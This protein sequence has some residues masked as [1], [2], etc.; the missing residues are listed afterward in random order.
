MWALAPNKS[1]SGNSTLAFL[2]STCLPLSGHFTVLPCGRMCF[3]EHSTS[4]FICVCSGPID[5]R[6]MDKCLLSVT[7]T[8]VCRHT[9]TH[10]HLS[11]CAS[12]VFV[13]L[14]EIVYEKCQHCRQGM[15]SGKKNL[16]NLEVLNSLNSQNKSVLDV[17]LHQA[18]RLLYVSDLKHV[19]D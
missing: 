7:Q 4:D 10:L 15:R 16:R 2:N 14:A 5:D 11:Y 9:H 6:L 1:E 17:I 12:G 13:G 3:W 19:Q 8:H 18:V